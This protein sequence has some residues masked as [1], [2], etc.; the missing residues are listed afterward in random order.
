MLL[1]GLR[2]QANW[3]SGQSHA[4]PLKVD[5]LEPIRPFESELAWLPDC[6]WRKEYEKLS[7]SIGPA[8]TGGQV[9]LQLTT[10]TN[11]IP[12]LDIGSKAYKECQEAIDEMS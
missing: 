9:G 5:L 8:A 10:L 11:A 4:I 1:S 6:E 12:Q 7:Q 3:V 2:R